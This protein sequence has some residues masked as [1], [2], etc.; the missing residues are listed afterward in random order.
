MKTPIIAL[1]ILLSIMGTVNGMA[2]ERV[3]PPEKLWMGLI[4]ETQKD[5]YQGMLGIACC[6]RN[7]MEQGMGHGLVAMRRTDLGKLVKEAGALRC[8]QAKRIVEIVFNDRIED[9]TRG[10]D[11]FESIRYRKPGWA[12][13]MRVTCRINEHVFYQQRKGHHGE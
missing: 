2:R 7:R 12:Y 11:H 3:K 4:G 1:V 9:I 13:D 5:D 8:A 6:V 10:A